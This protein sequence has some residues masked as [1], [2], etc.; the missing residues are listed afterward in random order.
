MRRVQS[1]RVG[2]RKNSRLRRAYWGSSPQMGPRSGPDESRTR[3]LM[4]TW[5]MAPR[6][7]KSARFR[8]PAPTHAIRRPSRRPTQRRYRT[9]TPEPATSTPRLLSRIAS[10]NLRQPKPSTLNQ[11]HNS[12][13]QIFEAL[14]IPACCLGSGVALLFFGRRWWKPLQNRSDQRQSGTGVTT[15]REA[16]KPA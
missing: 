7:S 9:A 15:P 11:R 5:T 6:P 13:Q 12:D 1:L 2:S 10:P 8:H 14:M 3:A 4:V 16:G